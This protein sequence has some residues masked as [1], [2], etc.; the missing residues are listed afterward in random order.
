MRKLSHRTTCLYA[1]CDIIS[2]VLSR[3]PCF[4]A[5]VSS[6]RRVRVRVRALKDGCVYYLTYEDMSVRN[7]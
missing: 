6:T 3:L 2:Y 4:H 1:T 5:N 7:F